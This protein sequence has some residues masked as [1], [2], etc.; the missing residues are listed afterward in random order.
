MRNH[1][2]VWSGLALTLAFLM[3]WVPLGQHEFLLPHWMKVGTFMAPFLV[4]AAISFRDETKSFPQDLRFIALMLLV[5]YI[6][7]QFEEHW[8]DVFGRH[9]AF[10]DSVN[11]LL[12]TAMGE[13]ADRPGPMTPETVFVINTSL[14]WFVGAL[15]VWRSPHDAFPLLCMAAIVLVNAVSH[16]VAAGVTG[17]YNPGLLTSVVV[18]IPAALIAY[19]W[20]GACGSAIGLSLLWAVLAHVIMIYGVLASTWLGL[21]PPIAY[22]AAL[23]FWSVVPTMASSAFDPFLKN[24]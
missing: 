7:H 16:I 1:P 17:L 23:V 4:F 15:A 8:V 6:A 24:T 11:N 10:Q 9:Y 19:R 20:S 14:V 22:Y 18:F 13:P 2:D 21:I 3:L 12:R 5:A